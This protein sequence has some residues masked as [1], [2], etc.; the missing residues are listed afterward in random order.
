MPFPG[1]DPGGTPPGIGRRPL[2]LA[3]PTWRPFK[4]RRCGVR[5]SPDAGGERVAVTGM[6]LVNALGNSPREI[7]EA[8]LAMRSGIIEVPPEKWDHSFYYD[9]DPRASEKTY[10]KVGAFQNID[11]N[12]KELGI[13]PQDF[14]TMSNSTRLTLWLAHHALADS[15]SW[16]PTSPGNAS[17][18]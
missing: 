14:R 18:C 5:P 3:H 2:T 4:A 1:Y 7:W 12:R 9:P 8:S 16:R 17:R 10:C 11:I 6:A 13:P 15:G